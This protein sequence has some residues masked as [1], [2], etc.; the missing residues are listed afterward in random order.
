MSHLLFGVIMNPMAH[1]DLYIVDN[2]TSEQSV[3]KYLNEWCTISR[4]MD[5]ATGYFEIGGLL[6]LDGEWQNLE[7]IRIILGS[8]LTKRTRNVLE[9]TKNYFLAGIDNSIEDEKEKNEF[10]RGVPAVLSAL[11]S[12]KIECRVFDKN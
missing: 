12:R 11:K 6:E 1:N 4:Q 7:K 10:L 8:E 9:E 3:K 2:S 5:I